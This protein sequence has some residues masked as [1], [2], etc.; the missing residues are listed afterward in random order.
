M[1]AF[2][3]FLNNYDLLE[4]RRIDDDSAWFKI[5]SCMILWTNHN[6]YFAKQLA[7]N[8][9]ASLCIDN[10]LCQSAIFLSVKV[11]KFEIKKLFFRIF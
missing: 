1:H 7:T 9:F 10:K 6:Y 5:D 3:L 4:D 2:W 8:Q 11:T